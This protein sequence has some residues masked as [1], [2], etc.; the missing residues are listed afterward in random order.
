MHHQGSGT[1][2]SSNPNPQ[3]QGASRGSSL[4]SS[5]LSLVPTAQVTN[6][7]PVIPSTLTYQQM[8]EKREKELRQKL[9]TFWENQNKESEENKNKKESKSYSLPL[10]RIKKIMKADEDVK[11]ISAEAPLIFAKACEMFI[12]D[13]TLRSWSNTEENKRRIL[14]RADVASAINKTEIFDFLVDVIPKDEVKNEPLSTLPRN[15]LSP[16]A[17]HSMVRGGVGVGSFNKYHNHLSAAATVGTQYLGFPGMS[18]TPGENYKM[19]NRNVVDPDMYRRHIPYVAPTLAPA[20]PASAQ[21][22]WYYQAQQA[23]EEEQQV[24]P[25]PAPPALAQH[26]WYQQAQQAEEEQQQVL[27]P[28]PPPQSSSDS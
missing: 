20:P 12:L 28:P 18:A 6:G 19:N 11:M 7:Q 8:Q 26:L 5:T 14:Q 1:G 25:P 2:D 21:V 15:V 23:K 27:P 16:T 22:Q 24:L 9:K 13:L 3:Q 4:I 10:A 17:D